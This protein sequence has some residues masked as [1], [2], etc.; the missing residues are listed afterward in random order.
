[1]AEEKMLNA[2]EVCL[3]VKCSYNALNY[4]YRFKRLNPD[5][6]YAQ[7]LPD[8]AQEQERQERLWK[9]SDV[10][11]ILEFKNSV[12]QGRNGIMGAITQKYRASYKERK[13]K[14]NGK[15]KRR[16]YRRKNKTT[17]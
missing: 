11:K 12:P 3:L 5:N 8:Y 2:L 13:K 17:E 7:L 6:E 1:M 10:E 9:Q 16:Q 15:T 14:K 4:W